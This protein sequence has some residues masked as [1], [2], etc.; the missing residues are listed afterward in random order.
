MYASNSWVHHCAESCMK[1]ALNRP[2]HEFTGDGLKTWISRITHIHPILGFRSLIEGV[3]FLSH[4]KR[5]IPF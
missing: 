1:L 3:L 2:I 5:V 4:E